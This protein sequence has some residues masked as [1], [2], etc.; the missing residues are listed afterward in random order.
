MLLKRKKYTGQDIALVIPTKDRPDKIRNLLESLSNQ[1]IKCGKIILVDG[2]TSVKN[3][4]MNY[5]KLLPLEYYKCNPPGQI[6]QRNFGITQ[7][8][9]NIELIGFID[10]D[11]IFKKDAFEKMIDF[12]NKVDSNTAGVGFN[13]M[14]SSTLNKYRKY[15]KL[16]QMD[17]SEP[18]KVIRSGYN[19]PIHNVKKDIRTQWLGGGYTIWKHAIIKNNPQN[20]LNTKWA[21]GE[22]LRYSYPIGKRYPLYICASAKV[23]HDHVYEHKDKHMHRYVGRKISL[24]IFYF[25]LM[26]REL[27]MLHC[28]YMLFGMTIGTLLLGIITTTPRRIRNALGHAE[29]ILI[30]I[31]YLITK[32]NIEQEIED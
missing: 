2:G 26:H 27:S 17:L 5:H 15:L 14:D 7:I 4:A 10:D 30:S 24:G 1:T 25:N 28:Y 23:H 29:A 11:M 18:G 12:W 6:R 3:V 19:A 13:L 31:T 32:R 21:I 20:I 9:D 22:D 8:D 16:I